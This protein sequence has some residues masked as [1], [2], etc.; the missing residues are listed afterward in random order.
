MLLKFADREHQSHA[1]IGL[2]FRHRPAI[3]ASSQL[4]GAQAEHR[5]SNHHQQH[6][7]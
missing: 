2:G 3:L 6:H 7:H 4:D 1:R 5:K